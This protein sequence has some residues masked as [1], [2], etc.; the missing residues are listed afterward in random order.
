[1]KQERYS[2]ALSDLMNTHNDKAVT[3]GLDSLRLGGA[4]NEVAVADFVKML[5]STSFA[6]K[7]AMLDWEWLGIYLVEWPH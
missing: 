4:N 3:E 6:C 5:L 7:D 2:T 1:M